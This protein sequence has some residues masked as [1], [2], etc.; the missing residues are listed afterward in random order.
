[1]IIVPFDGSE[2]AEAALVRAAQFGEVFD[3]R[4]LAVSVIPEGNADYA[5]ER[6]W[7]GEF[8][9]F[10]RQ[11]VVST[12]HEQV[13]DLAPGAEFQYELVGR[14]A[15]PGAIAGEVR[16]LADEKEATMVVVG[17][18]NAGRLVTGVS[19][20]GGNIATEGGYDVLIVRDSTP[21]EKAKRRGGPKE[22]IDKAKSDFYF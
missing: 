5:R 13:T 9:E 8:D 19:S 12:L 11:E 20:V 1:M 18:E 22:V 6:G 7:L 2:L 16:D 21:A 15:S 10:D 14:S 4:I 3:T 17:S